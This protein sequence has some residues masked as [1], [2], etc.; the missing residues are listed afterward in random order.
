L[1]L[2][3]EIGAMPEAVD[4]GKNGFLFA[5]AD[6]GDLTEAMKRALSFDFSQYQKRAFPTIEDEGMV[7]CHIYNDAVK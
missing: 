7:Y 5:P 3:S 6:A 4:V 1:V 2:A